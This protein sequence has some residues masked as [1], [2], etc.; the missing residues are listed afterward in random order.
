MDTQTSK[1]FDFA[2]ELTK[3]VMALS[4]AIIAL[5]AT[6]FEKIAGSSS[7]FIIFIYLSWALFILSIFLGF[8]CLGALTSALHDQ[9]GPVREP[10][11]WCAPVLSLSILQ[12]LA[13]IAAMICFVVY[14]AVSLPD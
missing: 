8:L 11:I 10:T 6:F 4:A 3:Q 14:A 7:E 9:K 1:S 5:S 2:N 13:F 12:Q